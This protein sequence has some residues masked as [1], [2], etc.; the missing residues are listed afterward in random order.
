M[1]RFNDYDYL[2]YGYPPYGHR[3]F[4]FGHPLYFGYG[5]GYG[6]VSRS[7]VREYV[8]RRAGAASS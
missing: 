7:H 1:E 8:Q 5:P 6:P 4:G 3:G 2:Y